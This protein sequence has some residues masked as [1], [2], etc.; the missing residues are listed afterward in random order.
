VRRL[1]Q[2]ADDSSDT[3]ESR[4]HEQ[5]SLHNGLCHTAEGLRVAK[6]SQRQRP[7]DTPRIRPTR[8]VAQ[9]A[10][11]GLLAASRAPNGFASAGDAEGNYDKFVAES[12]NFSV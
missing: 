12:R 10:Q 7:R 4:G 3:E 1:T 8:P 9:G 11:L 5:E 6:Q 2:N